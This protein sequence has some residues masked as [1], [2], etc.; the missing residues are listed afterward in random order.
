MFQPKKHLTL[1]AQSQDVI[2]IM[3]AALCD[4]GGG[5]PLGLG[6]VDFRQ[7]P[8]ARGGQVKGP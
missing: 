8:G 4:V 2:E 6:L 1:L 7:Q 5:A 3:R